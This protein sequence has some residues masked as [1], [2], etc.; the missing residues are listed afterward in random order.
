M[1]LPTFLLLLSH[2]PR[3]NIVY[4]K[5]HWTWFIAETGTNN[6]TVRNL[7]SRTR[8]TNGTF[9]PISLSLSLSLLVSHRKVN[10]IRLNRPFLP[11]LPRNRG[12]LPTSPSTSILVNN[13]ALA[14]ILLDPYFSNV[15]CFSLFRLQI[16]RLSR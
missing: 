16:V 6:S 3:L 14:S 11:S 13:R 9:F 1:L 7:R 12:Y 15:A 8:K 2:I 4:Q 5:F 10:E